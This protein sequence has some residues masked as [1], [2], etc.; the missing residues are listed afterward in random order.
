MRSQN[1]IFAI[2]SY[3]S[4]ISRS[5]LMKTVSVLF[6]ILSI[7]VVW[8]ECTFWV[9]KPTLSIFALIVQNAS[10]THNYFNLEVFC[11]FIISYLCFCAYSTLFQIKV[12]YYI[13][14]LYSLYPKYIGSCSFQVESTGRDCSL[15][16][17]PQLQMEN[18]LFSYSI[19]ISSRQIIKQ[20]TIHCFSLECFYV[21]LRHLYVSI[22]LG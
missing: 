19:S 2:K 3:L 18:F 13:L 15:R 12:S 6:G 14:L 7:L 16:Y 5:Y 17:K 10:K 9:K 4:V 1:I 20:T 8:S 22:F 11:I 21:V